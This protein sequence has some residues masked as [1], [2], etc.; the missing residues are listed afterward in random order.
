MAISYVSSASAAGNTVAMPTHQAGDLILVFAYR[1]DN[2]SAPSIGSGFS[3]I[4]GTGGGNTN[5]SRLA[6]KW[7]M[8]SSE[9]VGT[10]TNATEI[11]VHVYRGVTGIGANSVGLGSSASVT[12]PA[13]TLAKPGG[14][15]WVARFAGN[16][17]SIT[18]G[19][20]GGYTQRQTQT[21]VKGLDTNG[22]VSSNPGTATQA[23]TNTGWHA[24]SVE[25]RG[26]VGIPADTF[27]DAF[28]EPSTAPNP[29]I[30]IP[31]VANGGTFAVD[32][33]TQAL[34]VTGPPGI[35]PD[36]LTSVNT[37]DLTDGAITF[38]PVGVAGGSGT[39]TA[40]RFGLASDPDASADWG[41]TLNASSGQITPVGVG[42]GSPGSWDHEAGTWYRLRHAS[43]SVWWDSSADGHS[44]STLTSLGVGKP[45]A[46]AEVQ[47]T[48]WDSVTC[49]V[50]G[51][52]ELPPSGLP[53][54]QYT[55]GTWQQ[56]GVL[57][58]Y[59]G[60]EWVKPK[61]WDGSAWV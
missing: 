22:A 58:G 16:R 56:I 14:A 28:D 42:L 45:P 30:W 38:G 11:V 24:R 46:S 36:H 3:N 40:I 60:A 23:G 53:V 52:N 8:S 31:K 48:I 19:T 2:A 1:N 34:S 10:W 12:Y 20:P 41:F 51:I 13:L 6:Y 61:I 5:G 50:G 44:W 27:A 37:V 54:R 59:N 9:S 21:R 26:D 4:H 25:L 49:T 7:A 55:G 33:G 29:A 32:T 18:G 17:T 39:F 43:G 35:S 15:S 47:I 57:K